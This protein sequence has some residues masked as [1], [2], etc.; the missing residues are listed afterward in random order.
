MNTKRNNSTLSTIKGME[1]YE[2]HRCDIHYV[3][4]FNQSIAGM[5]GEFRRGVVE[6]YEEL[7]VDNDNISKEVGLNDSLH[8]QCKWV[9]EDLFR[10]QVGVSKYNTFAIDML[11][12][13]YMIEYIEGCDDHE[14][15]YF[16]QRMARCGKFRVGSKP[17]VAQETGTGKILGYDIV[18]KFDEETYCHL[19]GSSCGM[20]EN[21]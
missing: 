13:A 5:I 6:V 17:I 11:N 19:F 15:S 4:G 10:L 18:V 14:L 20:N 16:L 3:T 8:R 12:D 21:N 9:Q 7:T 1:K 2:R